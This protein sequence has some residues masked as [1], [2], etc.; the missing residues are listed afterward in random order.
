[1]AELAFLLG[2]SPVRFPAHSLRTLLDMVETVFLG[3]GGGSQM[4]LFDALPPSSEDERRRTRREARSVDAM[5]LAAP[6]DGQGRGEPGQPVA[7]VYREPFREGGSPGETLPFRAGPGREKALVAALLS[8]LLGDGFGG[9]RRARRDVYSSRE[10]L[11]CDR[12]RCVTTGWPDLYEPRFTILREDPVLLVCR[13]C[14]APARA[15]LVGSRHKRRYHPLTSRQVTK[16]KRENV[17]F[18]RDE[19]QAEAAGFVASRI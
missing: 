8:R 2:G 1:M 6:C 4:G 3:P 17:V 11:R 12:P 15:R 5:V 19:A 18:F 7:M 14:G 13:D 16:I 10:G 9:S